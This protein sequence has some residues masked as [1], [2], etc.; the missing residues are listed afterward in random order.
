L[1]RGATLRAEISGWSQSFDA[2]LAD[3][4]GLEQALRLTLAR[5]DVPASRLDFALTSPRG[6][7]GA[8]GCEASALRRVFGNTMPPIGAMAARGEASG[9]LLSVAMAV[10]ALQQGRLPAPGG[11][12]A[13][14]GAPWLNAPAEGPFRTGLIAGSGRNGS[15]AAV[16]IRKPA[17]AE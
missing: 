14:L 10:Q 4:A 2:E 3:G 11:A 7:R 6:E 5:A 9:G 16:L 8:D 17:M 13:G 1:T 15:H 12:L